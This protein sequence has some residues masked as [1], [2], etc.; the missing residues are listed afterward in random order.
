[1]KV[2]LIND[3]EVFDYQT[4]LTDVANAEGFYQQYRCSDLYSYFLNFIVA[5]ICNESI[6]L[7]DND[8]TDSEV[9]SLDLHDVNVLYP[10]MKNSV[11]SINQML[12]NIENSSSEIILYTSGTTGQP[13]SVIHSVSTLTRALRR[14]NHHSND[15]WG[16]AYNPTH[17]AGVQVF[18]QALLNQNTIVNLFN[19][20]RGDIFEAIDKHSITHLSATPTFYRL[21]LSFVKS[22]ESVQRIS[23]GGEKSD[24]KLYDQLYKLFPKAKLNNIYASTEAGTLFSSHGEN[25]QIPSQFERFIVE[26]EGELF[27]HHSLVGSLEMKLEEFYATGDLIEWIDKEQFIFRFI[28]R[29]NEML[30]VGGYKINPTEVENVLLQISEIKQVLVYCRPNSILGN[31]LCADVLL[32]YPTNITELDLRRHCNEHLQDFKVPRKIKFVDEISLTRT[33]KLRRQ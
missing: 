9:A 11:N 8:L 20:N 3:I 26:K 7:I 23:L 16:F 12:R 19:K 10:V 25:F 17:I 33:G 4:L 31:I 13:K 29:K 2:F 5:L 32:F 15:V 18:L 30:N 28:S 22:Y 1:M 27:I 6:K 21:L 14:S 24:K